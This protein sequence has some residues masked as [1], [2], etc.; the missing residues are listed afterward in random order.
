[1]SYLKSFYFYF[2]A[3]KINSVKIVKKIFFSTGHYNKSLK[4]QIPKRFYFFPNSYLLSSITNYRNFSFNLTDVNV[5]KLWT[6]Q[7]SEFEEKK[8]NSFLWLNLIDR[9]NDGKVIQKIISHW[10]NKNNRYK[11]KVWEN[12]VISRRIISWILNSEIIFTNTDAYFKENFLQ[13]IVLQ[14]NHLK[15]NVKFEKNNSKK[16]EILTA[17]L[18]S[19]LVFKE[20][21]ENFNLAIKELEKL[22]EE[23]FDKDGFP[24]SRNPNHLIKFSKYFIL[25]K[26]CTKDAQLLTPDFL[27]EIIEKILICLKKITTPES[28][29]PLFN[30]GT[31]IEVD[32]YFN[33][34][35]NL[36]YK[37]KTNN[38][39]VGNLN[40]LKYK[41]H[42]VFFDVGSPPKKN[43][44]RA[45]Q[46][47]PLSFEYFNEKKKI[48]TNC[49]FGYNISK[50]GMLLSRLTSAQSTLS[51]NDTSV[52]KFERNKIINKAFGNLIKSSF[53]VFDLNFLDDE[54]KT[55]SEATHDA[56]ET[57]KGYIHK[58]IIKIDK[59][60]EKLVGCDK[61]IKK[62]D[63]QPIKYDIRFHLTP[64][65]EAVQTMG[66]NSILIKINKNK[67]LIFSSK[68]ELISVEKSIF[69]GGNKILNNL[70]I[71]ITGNLSNENKDIN[72]EIKKNIN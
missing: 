42:V 3:I 33:Y 55:A 26:E 71:S 48:I 63:S 4:T 12:S 43:Y 27:D 19:G 52:L 35:N 70:C 30:G 53:K 13:S 1:M 61:L 32:E 22:V 64:G 51:I 58:R 47:G 44:S 28:K 68:N 46:C 10:I 67:S 37:I 8:I 69:L 21:I 16:I 23:F 7:T 17:I 5:D 25:I 56:Y 54:T 72:W 9:K 6:K 24:L 49:G 66:G 36:N 29:I 50:K 14:T 40:I 18:L 20:Y 39:F 31:E 2:L 62:K 38:S 15:N 34:I 60:N 65:I 57:S 45:Y 41:K 59:Q 11:K